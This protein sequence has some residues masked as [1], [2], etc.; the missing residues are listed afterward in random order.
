MLLGI[1]ILNRNLSWTFAHLLKGTTFQRM[2]K[3]IFCMANNLTEVIGTMAKDK[4][5]EFFQASL[6]KGK[7]FV[8]VNA[9][10]WNIMVTFCFLAALKS[11]SM[12]QKIYA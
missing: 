10:L 12:N 2:P 4:R 6:N 5:K 9:L 11:R 3:G 8:F 7:I 1:Y